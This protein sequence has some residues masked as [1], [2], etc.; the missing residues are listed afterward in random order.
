MLRVEKYV[1]IRI[2]K[3]SQDWDTV[4]CIV[5]DEGVGK[6]NLALHMLEYWQTKVFGKCPLS[7][8]KHMC[9]TGEDFVNDLSDAKKNELTA[10][11]E[12]GELDS[13]RAMSNFNVM[14]SQA[15]KV[16]RADRLFTLLVLPEF[17]DLETRFRN[18]RVKFLI[19]V[20]R[21]GRCAVWLKDKL[22]LMNQLNSERTIKSMY[23]VKP[24]FYD[25][26]PIYKG[27]LKEAYAEL[28]QKKTTETR[29]KLK[30]NLKT[31]KD[32]EERLK[33]AI[34]MRKLGYKNIDI[35]KSMGV[36]DSTVCKWFKKLESAT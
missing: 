22:R 3:H 8:I 16:I 6:S 21:R 25:T 7:D 20:Y 15:Y 10:F 28:K 24:D 12:A 27:K 4:G 23:A 30:A 33:I 19:H 17:F 29:Q 2:K 34:N 5:G 26:F 1:D 35:A 18:R 9:L 31:N 14:L 32:Q 11:D 36:D 13:R